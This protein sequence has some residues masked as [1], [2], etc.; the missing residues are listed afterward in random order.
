MLI[1]CSISVVLFQFWC[2]N[3]DVGIKY[4]WSR[5]S[6]VVL[7][8]YNRK[9]GKKCHFVVKHQIWWVQLCSV[10]KTT[11]NR[12]SL[13]LCWLLFLD[14]IFIFSIEFL[15]KLT[16]MNQLSICAFWSWLVCLS[17]RWWCHH[18]AS[19]LQVQRSASLHGNHIYPLALHQLWPYPPLAVVDQLV[20][21]H[22]TSGCLPSHCVDTRA[23][24]P[25]TGN[26]WWL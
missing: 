26:I 23:H 17:V 19:S 4:W 22:A 8:L 18:D 20:S 1:S 14:F 9:Q 6:D 11:F 25:N 5:S 10:C 3:Y 7:I 21:G 2:R 15:T 16:T 24:P 13:T 12:I